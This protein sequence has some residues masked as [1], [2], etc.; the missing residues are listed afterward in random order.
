MVNDGWHPTVCYQCKA[1]C[2]IIAKIENGKVTEVKG[3][4]K[5]RG[6]VCVKGMAGI[7]LQY[8]KDRL[9]HPLRRV[10]ERGEGKFEKISWD[11]AMDIIEE[12]LR[13]LYDR[14]EAHKL[15]Y[16]F[17]PHS[18]TDPKW[19]FLNA[20][21]GYI[22]TGL[23]HCDSAKIVSQIK[24]WGGIPNHHIP[25][26]WFTMPGDGVM[27]LMGRHAF[28]CLDDANVPRDILEAKDRGAKLIVVDPI[29][30]PDAAKADWWIPIR[31]SGDTALL[32]GMIHY[33]IENH[34]YNK[35]FVHNYV[36]EGDFEKVRAYIK[37]KTP[38][39][40]SK[41]CDVPADDI[42]KLARICA[43]ASVVGLDGFKSIML[44]Q[45]MDFG[46]AWCI[47]LAITGSI[48][49][50]GGQPIPDLTPLSPVEP[51]PPG[52]PPL[53]EKGFHRT[54]PNRSKFDRYSF[55]LEPTWYE[56]QA[57]RDDGLKILIVTE[58]NPALTEMGSNDWQKAVCMKD[59]AGNYKLEFLLN[60][61]IMLSETGKFSDLIL[62][63][64]THFERWELLYMPWW[65]NFGH[66]LALR[67]PLVKPVGE[68]RHSNMVFIE[69]GKRMFPE[70]FQFKDD[71]EYYDLQM[72][73]LG[74]SV[75]KLQ[76][77]NCLWSPGSMGF[78]KYRERGFATP[79]K[80]VHLY[81]EDMEDIGRALPR[82]ILAPEYDADVEKY[83]FIMVSYRRIHIN[84]TG[85]WSVNNAQLRDPI[86]G[87]M[88]NPVI[89][90]PLAGVRLGIKD[91]DIIK[92]ES[93]TGKVTA[94][95]KF[96][97]HIRP[98]CVGIMHGFGA[99]VG[100]VA[101][102]AGVCDNELI[103]D[104]GAHLDWQDL[105]GGEAHVSTRVQISK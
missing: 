97:E 31:P 33:I 71:V 78:C 103:P 36:R 82:P 9:T 86:S 94:P 17:F 14:G 23:P 16:S 64:Q 12:K 65:Y 51:V 11:A 45:A 79:S 66:G 49:N 95:V 41:I 7:T 76:E 73:G 60:T 87:Q 61:D 99:T 88:D 26:A 27:L 96:T 59:S 68:A 67:Q 77:M 5:K 85:P 101:A 24:C 90:N 93:R 32:L 43:E 15:T 34:L 80:K 55:I 44:G 89:L 63:D 3:H 2:A 29:F 105:I 75:K 74:L 54:G 30:S 92:I 37:D 52:P 81:W 91:G 98:D 46:H 28:G 10:G 35:D 1:E 100:R 18:L 25:P 48:D 22:N 19:R 69:M 57:I 104:A 102:G 62:P 20:Y 13:S 39:A 21:G 56:A 47:F 38:E 83:P 70:Y 84:G 72:R 58:A 6:K 8:S 42:R 50:P 40:M 53:Q 4:P